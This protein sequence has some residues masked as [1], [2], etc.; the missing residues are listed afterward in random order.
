MERDI[1][2][3]NFLLGFTQRGQKTLEIRPHSP[4][5][6]EFKEGDTLNFNN[7]FTRKI[8]SLRT[9][10]NILLLLEQ[11]VVGKIY[12]YHTAGK[13]LADLKTVYPL[14]KLLGPW[15]VIEI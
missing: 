3:K 12:P 15:L 8:S 11:E 7:R 6:S 13:L 14:E 10:D 1:W 5:F 4:P 9:Y 2:I